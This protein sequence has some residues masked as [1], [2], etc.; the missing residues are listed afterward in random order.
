MIY[1]IIIAFLGIFFGLLL[2]QA[3]K[4]EIKDGRKYIVL[5]KDLILLS[6]III[7]IGQNFGYLLF[8]GAFIGFFLRY[9]IKNAYFYIGLILSLNYSLL[10]VCLAFVFGIN[11]GALYKL[12]YEFLYF[13]PFLLLLFDFGLSSLFLGVG[14]GGLFNALKDC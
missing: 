13:V 9:V 10:L 5:F 11:H 4:E 1:E 12:K 8:L 14:I 2:K 6:I 3:T 7:A